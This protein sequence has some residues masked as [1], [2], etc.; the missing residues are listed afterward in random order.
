[1][2]ALVDDDSHHSTLL[3][4]GE[5]TGA[6]DTRK[7]FSWVC[8]EWDEMQPMAAQDKPVPGP[9]QPASA[10]VVFACPKTLRPRRI[11]AIPR[12]P[13]ATSQS[14]ALLASKSQKWS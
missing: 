7:T 13:T 9:A 5:F 4:F 3:C 1:M 14:L 10:C 11:K 8:H 6:R 2:D 12:K